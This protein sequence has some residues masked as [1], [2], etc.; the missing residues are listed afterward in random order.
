MV[1][2][3]HEH[4]DHLN[5]TAVKQLHKIRPTLIFC[6]GEFLVDKLTTAGVNANSIHIVSVNQIFTYE[7]LV[8]FQPVE[9]YHD[10]KNIGYKIH[11]PSG[12]KVLYA[13]D[14]N[15]I[16]HITA[17]NYDLYLLEAN[18]DEESLRRNAAEKIREGDYI[19]EQRVRDTHLSQKQADEFLVENM[20]DRSA[21][22]YMHVSERNGG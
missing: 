10:V 3:T 11:L 12:E 6:C 20:G 13:T 19:Y 21:F 14:T 15:K 5:L 7:N 2:L 22:V 4:G 18:Y 8:K 9:L 16:D 17:K 1:L